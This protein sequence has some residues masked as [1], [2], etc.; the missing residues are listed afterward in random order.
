MQPLKKK[1][2]RKRLWA[3]S[4][5]LVPS[6]IEQPT[7]GCHGDDVRVRS[8]HPDCLAISPQ[9]GDVGQAKAAGL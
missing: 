1:K 5:T 9:A 3:W 8:L 2:E 6:T 7:V 4:L